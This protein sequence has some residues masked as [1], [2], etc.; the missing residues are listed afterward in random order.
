[1]IVVTRLNGS[2]F[3]VN[4]DLVERIL[5]TPDTTLLMVDGARFVV[6]ESMAEVIDLIA[7]YRARIVS[8]AYGEQAPPVRSAA[9][10]GHDAQAP[11]GPTEHGLARVSP[12]ALV[13]GGR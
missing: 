8:L 9:Q 7:T 1:M 12:L 13:D 4:P 2:A 10:A 6:T 11:V 5:S 3:A